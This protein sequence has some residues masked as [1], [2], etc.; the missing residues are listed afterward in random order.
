MVA[1]NAILFNANGVENGQRRT[2]RDEVPNDGQLEPGTARLQVR[3]LLGEPIILLVRFHSNHKS[4]VLCSPN[5]HNRS[6]TQNRDVP[7]S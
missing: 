6:K 1:Y 2:R 3:I 5:Y 4:L 7:N